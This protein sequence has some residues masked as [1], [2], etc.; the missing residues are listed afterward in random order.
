M[1]LRP[2]QRVTLFVPLLLTLALFAQDKPWEAEVVSVESLEAAAAALNAEFKPLADGATPEQKAWD[3]ARR[4]RLSLLTEFTEFAK[5]AGSLVETE[6]AAAQAKDWAERTAALRERP[7]EALP[8]IRAAAD[9]KD[10]KEAARSAEAATTKTEKRLKQLK[11]ISRDAEKRLAAMPERRAQLQETVS[12]TGE[13]PKDSIGAY[14]RGNAQLELRLLSELESNASNMRARIADESKVRTAQLDYARLVER[15]AASRLQAGQEALEASGAAEVERLKAE[16]AR[17]KA[18]ADAAKDPV[19][20]F[21]AAIQAQIKELDQALKSDESTHSQLERRSKTEKA[22]LDQYK[23]RFER[24]NARIRRSET[25]TAGGAK[26]L[27]EELL[28][29]DRRGETIRRIALPKVRQELAQVERNIVNVEDQK[30]D[31][32]LAP[33][34]TRVWQTWIDPLPDQ[35]HAEGVAVFDELVLGADG[36]RARLRARLESLNTTYREQSALESSYAAQLEALDNVEALIRSRIYWV[37]TDPRLGIALFRSAGTELGALGSFYAETE[38]RAEWSA[39]FAAQPGLIIGGML[40]LCL[41]LAGGTIAARRLKAREMRRPAEGRRLK[42][43]VADAG[44]MLIHA[45]VPSLVLLLAAALVQ[46]LEMPARVAFP[47]EKSLNT[48]ALFLFLQR[49]AWGLLNEQGFLVHHFK[50]DP[51]VGKQALRSVRIVTLGAMFFHVPELILERAPFSA[52]TLI[53][54]FS[55]AF[56]GCKLLA[57]LLLLPR[58]GPVAQAFVGKSESGAR[59]VGFISPLMVLLLISIFVMDLLGYRYGAVFFTER[60]VDSFLTVLVLRAVYSGLNQIS[61]RVVARV[62]ARAHSESGSKAAW[63]DSEKVAPQLSRVITVV[64]LAAAAVFLGGSWDIGGSFGS[65]L[66][67]WHV[68]ELAGEGNYISMLNILVAMFWIFGAH[69]FASNI[70]GVFELL[71]FPVFGTI[72]RGT[73]YVVLALSRYLILLIGYSAALVT[74]HFSIQ[75]VGWLLAAASVGLGFGL[76]EIVANFISGLI[77]LVEQPVRVGDVI[78]VGESGGTVDKITIRS[79]IVT[80]WDQQQI[81]IPN[82]AFITQ[83]LTNWTRNNNFTRRKI[84][85]QLAYGSDVEKAISILEAAVKQQENVR[86]YPPPRI[87]FNGFGEYGL[88]IECWIYVDIDFGFSTMSNVR[89][90]ILSALREAG[91]EIP[92]PKRDVYMHDADTTDPMTDLQGAAGTLEDIDPAPGEADDKS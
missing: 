91:I 92:L 47:I 16:A 89:R 79:T 27:H 78:T 72:H 19:H 68:T 85:L 53:R 13:A 59:F 28:T 14:R 12:K 70:A 24:L 57:L 55:T 48:I 63:E 66:D 36:L 87:W 64:T 82:K 81:F 42:V 7:P 23:K 35:R 25:V 65:I 86:S 8:E 10:L 80:N 18:E 61:D 4:A 2:Y 45:V 90:A 84:P 31:L 3:T 58:R 20:R 62:R 34:D 11:N 6:D 49:L 71:I 40:L 39:T 50:V 52:D 69:F 88:Q 75:S 30:W 67:D 56:R 21:R 46:R 73:R 51:A 44:R 77:L 76:Q 41:L 74:L 54:L 37:R 17:A 43:G 9:L 29:V 26:E 22:V 33:Q 15:R 32:E 5:A 60:A 38:F 83:N 1:K